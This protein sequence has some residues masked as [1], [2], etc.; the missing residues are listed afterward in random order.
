MEVEP[1]D[2]HRPEFPGRVGGINDIGI[3]TAPDGSVYAMS[4]MTV[5][6]KSDGASQDLMQAVTRQ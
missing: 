6:N 4:I 1:Q 5:L 3:L 2:R